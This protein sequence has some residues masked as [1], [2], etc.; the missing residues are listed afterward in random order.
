MYLKKVDPT[1]IQRA[2]FYKRSYDKVVI[3]YSVLE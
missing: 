1:D 2:A 3:I